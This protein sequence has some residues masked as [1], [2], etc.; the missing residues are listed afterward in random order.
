MRARAALRAVGD[1]RCEV[2]RSDPP[3]TFRE[4]S[5][6]LQ[7]VGSAAAP[8][9]GDDLALALSVA[10]GAVLHVGS[11]AASLAHPGPSGA[12]STMSI[13]GDVD[14]TLTWSPQPTVLVRDCDHR[15]V[16]R[17]RVGGHGRVVWR[18]EAVLGRHGEVPGSMTQRLDV[19]RAGR[20][21]LRTQLAVGPRWPGSLGPAGT[22]GTR[23]IGSLLVVGAGPTHPVDGIRAAVQ[24]LDVDA[25]LVTALAPRADALRAALDDWL[26]GCGGWPGPGVGAPVAVSTGR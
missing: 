9:G 23:A 17:L 24:R 2:L 19:E 1:G 4:T 22:A 13:E 10:A 18:E 11:V 5:D 6:G 21:L 7:W 25:V 15:S 8:V 20:P 14:G 26:E 12:A 16:T 3:L